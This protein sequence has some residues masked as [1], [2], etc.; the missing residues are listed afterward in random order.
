[1]KYLLHNNHLPKRPEI[2]IS[3]ISR[4]LEQNCITLKDVI[5]YYNSKVDVLLTM[6]VQYITYIAHD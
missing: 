1:M 6:S 3:T 4:T 5:T 2:S